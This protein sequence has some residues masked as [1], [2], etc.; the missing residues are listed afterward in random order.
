M[1]FK[2]EALKTHQRLCL[3]NPRLD[4]GGTPPRLGSGGSPLLIVLGKFLNLIPVQTHLYT[5][6]NTVHAVLSN[7]R[8][9]LAQ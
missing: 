9:F 2:G 1:G 4:S 7:P 6:Y 8:G 5:I 3:W